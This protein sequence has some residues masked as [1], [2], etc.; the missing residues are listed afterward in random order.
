MAEPTLDRIRPTALGELAKWQLHFE[1]ALVASGLDAAATAAVIEGVR[2]RLPVLLSSAPDPGLAAPHMRAF[3]VS[4][5]IYVAMYLELASRGQ[6]AAAAWAI[7]EAATRARFAAMKGLE[8]RLATDGMFGWP[9]RALSRWLSKRS[10]AAPV[11]GWVFSFV[12][13]EPGVFDYGV[14]YERCA[15]REMAIANGAGDFAPYICLADVPGS[16]E[17]GWGLART[18]TLAQGGR[19]CDFRFKKGAE[20]SVKVRLP[21]AY[22][23]PQPHP[24]VTPHPPNIPERK[25]S[26]G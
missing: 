15:I 5:V 7:C 26:G 23:G 8:K 12:E 20:T 25:R 4:G 10:H 2:A 11:G 17:F 9:M 1:R 6:S 13:G 22:P 16:E 18:E 19:R 24:G 21:V 14:D 3:S